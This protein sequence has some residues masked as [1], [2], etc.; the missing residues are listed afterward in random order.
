MGKKKEKFTNYTLVDMSTGK[1][2]L[3]LSMPNGIDH[4]ARLKSKR[5]AVSLDR[6]IPIE[7]LKWG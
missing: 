3:Q 5:F 1:H 7:N 4:E 2:V 6:K